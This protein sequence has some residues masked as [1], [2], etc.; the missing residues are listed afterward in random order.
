MCDSL[1]SFSFLDIGIL[2]LMF[3]QNLHSSILFITFKF[4]IHSWFLERKNYLFN[5][6]IIHS[7]LL[8]ILFHPFC[9]I[10]LP[11]IH[12]CSKIC[13]IRFV[14]HFL[15][16]FILAFFKE[17]IIYSILLPFIHSCSKSCFHPFGSILL[18]FIHSFSFK[19]L[20]HPLGSLLLPFIHSCFLQR[21]NYSF[22]TFIIHSFIHA[23]N[24]C[25]I[26]FVHYFLF[27]I[28]SFLLSSKKQ[29]EKEH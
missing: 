23:R 13:F 26:H 5:S 6:C 10:L 8:E 19:I 14:H 15:F 1:V 9:S 21:K 2:F 3:I 12:S 4:F 24:L 25:F 11:F 29:E 18:P 27:F 22:I 7:F 20:F 16:S 17:R 28:H